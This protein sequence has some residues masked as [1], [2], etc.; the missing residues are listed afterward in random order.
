MYLKYF[1]L[2]YYRKYD[3]V[4]VKYEYYLPGL[5][6]NSI[7]FK[8]KKKFMGEIRGTIGRLFDCVQNF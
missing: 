4:I 2:I 3:I 5:G 1:F 6:E 7:H 8:K